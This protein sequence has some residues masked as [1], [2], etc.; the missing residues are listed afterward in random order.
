MRLAAFTREGPGPRRPERRVRDGD[1]RWEPR[2]HTGVTPGR[3]R[4][5]GSAAPP[6]PAGSGRANL[7]LIGPGQAVTEAE[8]RVMIGFLGREE[9]L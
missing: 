1:P 6:P 2:G 4:L 7:A 9:V 5:T 3:A 8:T